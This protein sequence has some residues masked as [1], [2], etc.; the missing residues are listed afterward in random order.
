MKEA[1]P[2]AEPQACPLWMVWVWGN[3][4]ATWELVILPS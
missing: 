1:M 2:K 3:V 4:W